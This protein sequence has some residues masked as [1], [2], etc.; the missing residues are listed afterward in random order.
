MALVRVAK[1]GSVDMS[2]ELKSALTGFHGLTGIDYVSSFFKKSKKLKKNRFV[3]VFVAL[4]DLWQPI[5]YLMLLKKLCVTCLEGSKKNINSVHYDIFKA[6]Y[7]K[8]GKNQD[9]SLLPPSLQ[10]LQLHCKWAYYIA[11]IWRSCL[12]RNIDFQS[13]ENSG[14]RGDGTLVWIE[15]AFPEQIESII[16]QTPMK[17]TLMKLMSKIAV[18]KLMSKI[19][20]TKLMSKIAV[21]KLMSKI[22]VT[23]LMSK[24]A[25]TKLMS[26]I[27][28]TNLMSKIAVT[29]RMK[30][31]LNSRPEF[32]DIRVNPKLQ[33]PHTWKI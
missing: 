33:V 31:Y 19:A 16:R 22:A 26:K 23:K 9:L 21:T 18:T 14:W 2:N 4:G 32:K 30:I 13:V 24:I 7:T 15:E 20:V 1:L 27:A 3:R 12:N 25:V 17:A 6:V 8:K 29:V 11:K 10:S 28:V 5:I